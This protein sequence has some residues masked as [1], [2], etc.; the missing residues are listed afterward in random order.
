MTNLY[1]QFIL[2]IVF[3]KHAQTSSCDIV[4]GAAEQFLAMRGYTAVTLKDIVK[5]LGIEKVLLYHHAFGGKED[6]YF[7]VMLRHLERRRLALEKLISEAQS[8]L[9]NEL[10]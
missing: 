3:R 2:S 9:E 4:L 8:T 6:L 10:F 5:K 7:E 1:N